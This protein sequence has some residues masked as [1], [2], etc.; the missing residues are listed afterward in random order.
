MYGNVSLQ[1]SMH[2]FLPL[3][4][5]MMMIDGVDVHYFRDYQAPGYMVNG[6]FSVSLPL[7]K[8]IRHTLIT[9]SSSQILWP[10]LVFVP[11]PKPIFTEHLLIS[12]KIGI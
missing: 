5:P 10:W 4:H 1:F 11:V 9:A 7:T 12:R 6:F 3:S 2:T 8:L